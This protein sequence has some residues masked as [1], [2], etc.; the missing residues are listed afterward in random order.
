MDSGDQQQ[1]TEQK[2]TPWEPAQPWMKQNLET[3]Q[4][5]QRYLEQNPFNATQKQGYQSLLTGVDQFNQGIAPGLYGMA[6][7]LAGSTYS[8]QRG[9]APGSAAGYGGPVQPGGM[10][11]RPGNI[12]PTQALQAQP[13]G[14]INWAAQNPFSKDNPNGIGSTP[15][16]AAAPAGTN[17]LEGLTP[18][19]MNLLLQMLGEGSIGGLLM[20]DMGGGGG[21]AGGAGSM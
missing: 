15:A 5:L 7:N 18:E 9:G 1:S 10:S 6:N 19:Q 21:G 2:R 11:Q 12:F 3:G 16:P 20:Q 17:P 13:Y 8:R 4:N 14:Q